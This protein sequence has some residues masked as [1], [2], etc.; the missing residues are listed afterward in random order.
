MLPVSQEGF[1][2][3][4]RELRPTEHQRAKPMSR[5]AELFREWDRAFHQFDDHHVADLIRLGVPLPVFLTACIGAETITPD[6]ELYVPDEN[7]RT[8]IILPIWDWEHPGPHLDEHGHLLPEPYPDPELVLVDLIAWLPSSADRWFF[9]R[10]EPALMLGADHVDDAAREE[11][12][13]RLRLN[14]L[15]WLRDGCRG[16][17]IINP[18]GLRSAF[19]GINRIDAEDLALGRWFQN[20]M[21]ERDPALPVVRVPES[22]A[23]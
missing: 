23:A 6:G 16:C 12:P 19:T 8:A 11:I 3:V 10:G 2:R 13:V 4:G 14:P 21:R 22:E 15:S 5:E 9:R 1:G 17:C 7:G 18:T 20:W